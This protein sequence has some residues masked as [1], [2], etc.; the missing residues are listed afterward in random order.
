MGRDAVVITVALDAMGG[1]AGVT[2]TVQ[3]A[4]QL[5]LEDIAISVLLVGDVPSISDV[6]ET[7][8]YNPRKIGIVSADGVAGMDEDPKKALK[9]KPNC[10]VARAV[11]LV[12]EGRADAVV[13]A[14]HTGALIL[15][16]SKQMER[17]PGIRRAALAAVHPTEKRHGPKGDPF[18]LMLDVG[19]TVTVDAETLV[20]FAIMGAAYS[21]VISE[22]ETP[23]L[24]RGRRRAAPGKEPPFFRPVH[25]GSPG[26]P[27]E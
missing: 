17:L 18:A 22:I 6:L 5:S 16:A 1:D 25:H 27:G 12:T 26:G 4:A 23:R 11:R 10:S 8:D 2:A 15:A 19:A 13:S 14:G 20:G 7:V 9:E 3:G 21:H 24:L